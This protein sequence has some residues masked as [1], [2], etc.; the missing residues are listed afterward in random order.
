MS[1][2]TVAD[3]SSHSKRHGLRCKTPTDSEAIR[4]WRALPAFDGIAINGR[5]GLGVASCR[6]RCPWF[7]GGTEAALAPLPCIRQRRR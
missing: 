7:Y 2:E 1:R 5:D 4:Q 6:K 3:R